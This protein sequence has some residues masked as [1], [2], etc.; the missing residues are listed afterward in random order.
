MKNQATGT[1]VA[2]FEHGESWNTGIPNICLVHGKFYKCGEILEDGT[3]VSGME[4]PEPKRRKLD[5]ATKT[6]L[7]EAIDKAEG[8]NGMAKT[9]PED[10]AEKDAKPDAEEDA[11]RNAEEDAKPAAKE[12]VSRMPEPLRS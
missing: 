5:Q 2:C 9:K 7:L 8:K 3:P 11:K 10:E 4:D 12:D 1:I 6:E